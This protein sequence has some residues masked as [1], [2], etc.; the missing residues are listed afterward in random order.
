MARLGLKVKVMVKVRDQSAVGAT[1]SEGMC[2]LVGNV[3]ASDIR[4]YGS[5]AAESFGG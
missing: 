4:R 3:L 5:N 1:S 2:I